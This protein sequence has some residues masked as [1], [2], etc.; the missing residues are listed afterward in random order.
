MNVFNHFGG[1]VFKNA[2]SVALILLSMTACAIEKGHPE[3]PPKPEGPSPIDKVTFTIDAKGNLNIVG[4]EGLSVKDCS[5]NS[6]AKDRCSFFNKKVE[7]EELENIF[8]MRYKGS[9]CVV[10]GFRMGAKLI[11][12]P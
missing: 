8:L 10:V 12:F 1:R 5:L 6:D 7:I 9:D 2:A 3:K 4:A 11:C